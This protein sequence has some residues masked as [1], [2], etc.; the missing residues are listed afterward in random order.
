MTSDDS[1]VVSIPYSLGEADEPM[2]TVIEA[3]AKFKG[4]DETSL[5]PLN[6]AV[7]VDA[8]GTLFGTGVADPAGLQV[9][10]EYEG[11]EVVVEE[12]RVHVSLGE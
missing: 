5:A 1:E 3:V 4:V 9:T 12:N 7:D 6:D 10:F 11:C 8:L 2:M